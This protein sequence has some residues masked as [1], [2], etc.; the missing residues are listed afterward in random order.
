MGLRHSVMALAAGGVL[1]LGATPASAA[2]PAPPG[3]TFNETPGA[4]TC[5]TTSTETTRFG[6]YTTADLVPAE[7]V[8]GPLTGED[9][10]AFHFGS[11]GAVKVLLEDLIFT[12]SVTT[13]TTT[14]RRGLNGQVI[15]TSTTTAPP[16]Y[17][18]DSGGLGCL[19]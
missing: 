1:A 5:T 16:T 7:T 11:S 2:P 17:S 8:F 9:I 10:C 4:L 13:T 15:D 19:F 12:R 14:T 18:R 6:P 3:C